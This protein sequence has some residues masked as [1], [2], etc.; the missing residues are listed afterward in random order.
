MGQPKELTRWK[1]NFPGYSSRGSHGWMKWSCRL[2]VDS[3][4][5]FLILWLWNSLW[6][7]MRNGDL[8][9]SLGTSSE[10]I[11]CAERKRCGAPVSFFVLF[12]LGHRRSFTSFLKVSRIQSIIR[13]S[14][15][16]GNRF[17]GTHCPRRTSAELDFHLEASGSAGRRVLWNGLVT[18]LSG[19][20]YTKKWSWAK[21]I[22]IG[23]RL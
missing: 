9:E 1:I 4:Q 16:A 22:G 7:P 10:W 13:H 19:C 17:A 3:D 14:R 12:S 23:N 15:S 5:S 6:W 2:H 20:P 21:M 8:C 11:W 18:L